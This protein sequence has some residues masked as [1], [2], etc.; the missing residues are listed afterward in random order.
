VSSL[1][2][3]ATAVLQ[4]KEL[5]LARA[6]GNEDREH[7]QEY[8]LLRRRLIGDEGEEI[9]DLL[10]AFVR[11]CRTLEE[12]WHHIRDSYP[13]YQSRRDYL[14]RE[15]TPLLDFLEGIPPEAGQPL[16]SILNT[17]P[18]WEHVTHDWNKARRRLASDPDGAIT[19]ARA[20]LESVCKHILDDAGIGYKADD[21]LPNL[22]YLT[23]QELNLAPGQHQEEGFKKILGNA[24]AVVNELAALRNDQG[25]AHGKGRKAYR[26]AARHAEL[27]VGFAGTIASFLVS[28]WQ[29]RKG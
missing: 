12:F 21:S 15:F 22:Y 18:D 5:L 16:F 27:A 10:P 8:H 20:L 1:E 17:L 14:H 23:V 7:F 3:Q 29:Q 2:E 25:D 6:T 19:S 4:I 11:S 13:N 24:Q 9:R 26:P 28:T